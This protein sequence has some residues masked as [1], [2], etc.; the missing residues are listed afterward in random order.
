MGKFVTKEII[1]FDNINKYRQLSLDNNGNLQVSSLN[2]PT[3]NYQVLTKQ[4]SIY[5]GTTLVPLSRS[6][7]TLSLNG[8]GSLFTNTSYTFNSGYWANIYTNYLWLGT[9]SS[10]TTG[11]GAIYLHNLSKSYTW[12]TLQSSTST[13]NRVLTLPA[14]SNTLVAAGT[15]GAVNYI[16]VANSTTA[17]DAKWVQPNISFFTND[18]KYITASDAKFNDYVTLA[19]EQTISGKKNF[20]GGATIKGT[21]NAVI[22]FNGASA[23][24]DYAHI[25]V[26]GSS[27]NSRPLVLQNGYGNVAI[28]NIIAPTNKLEVE[29]N[30]KA[31]KFIGD[32]EASILSA[33]STTIGNL[34]VQGSSSLGTINSGTWNASKIDKSYLTLNSIT[35]GTA[36]TSSATSGSSIS[37]PY[38]SVDAQGLVTGYGTHTHTIPSSLPANGGYADYPTGFNSRSSSIGWGTLTTGN[39]YTYLTDWHTNAGS[40]IAFA[41]KS[42]A[43]SVQ[44]DGYF[45]QREGAARVLDT[46]DITSTNISNWNSTYNA[47]LATSGDVQGTIDRWDEV[48]SFLSTVSEGQ[49]L[50]SILQGYVT[51]NTAQTISGAKTFQSAINGNILGNATT[52]DRWS[53]THNFTIKDSDNTNSGTA[54]AVDGSTDYILHLP[55]TIKANITG[56]V[57]G[58][59]GS[60]AWTGITGKPDS[61][62]P[63]SHNHTV[64]KY[65]DSRDTQESPTTAGTYDGLRIDFKNKNTS[66]IPSNGTWTTVITMDGYSDATGGYPSQ[67][68]FSMSD[69]NATRRL[70]FRSP[71]NST[72]WGN[73]NTLAFTSDL[74]DYV[75]LDTEQTITGKKVLTGYTKVTKDLGYNIADWTTAQHNGPLEVGRKSNTWTLTLGVT[76]DSIGFIQN[77]AL[78]ISSP[79]FLVLNPQG[80]ASKTI[81]G[82][83]YYGSVGI[84][85][86]REPHYSLEVN[87]TLGISNAATLSSSLAVGTSLSVGTT[88]SFSGRAVFS[89]GT[90]NGYSTG[91]IEIRGNGE[92]NTNPGLGFHQPGK[93]AGY[94]KLTDWGQF[95]LVDEGNGKSNLTAQTLTADIATGT[96]PLNITSITKV[97][98]LNSDLLDGYHENYF[99]SGFEHQPFN[100]SNYTDYD[101]ENTYHKAISIITKPV[102]YGGITIRGIVWYQSSNDRNV[103]VSKFPF[104]INISAC[105]KQDHDPLIWVPKVVIDKF[106]WIFRVVRTSDY[107]YEV[108]I[109]NGTSRWAELTMIYQVS[110]KGGQT[111]TNYTTSSNTL[112]TAIATFDIASKAQVLSEDYCNYA[113]S[114][115]SATS[116]T[117]TTYLGNS[118]NNLSYSSLSGVASRTISSSTVGYMS[119][120]SDTNTISGTELF[121]VDATNSKLT[122]GGQLVTKAGTNTGAGLNGIKLASNSVLTGLRDDVLLLKNNALRFSNVDTWDYDKWAGLKYDS[123]NKYIYLG[124]ADGTIFTANNVQSNGKLLL[125]GIAELRLGSSTSANLV[126]HSGNF[127]AGTNYVTPSGS[128]TGS[129]GSCTGNSATATYWKMQTLAASTDLNTM[130]TSGYYSNIS[131]SS[132]AS[133][134]NGPSG[135]T[136]GEMWMDVRQAGASSYGSQTYYARGGESFQIYTRTWSSSNFS[137]WVQILHTENINSYAL[138]LS[139]NQTI[140]GNKTFSGTTSLSIAEVDSLTAGNLVVQGTISGRLE[141]TATG[142]TG[143]TFK[144]MTSAGTSGWT[145]NA[146]DDKIIPTMSVLAYWNGAYSGNSSNITKLGTISNGTWQASTIGL[147]YGGTGATTAAGARTNLGLDSL[148]TWYTTELGDTDTKINKW[149]EV[150]YFLSTITDDKTLGDILLGYVTKD[151][152]QTIIGAKTFESPINGD[153]LGNATTADRLKNGLPKATN[154]EIGG[155][156][157][158]TTADSSA[159]T[160]GATSGYTDS[161]TNRN[162][163]V[164]M[165]SN[166]VAYVNIPWRNDTYSIPT[167]TNYYA[168]NIQ[169]TSSA[170][171]IKE[172]EFK[173]IKINGST[174]NA[175]ST[176]NCVMQY[177]TTNKCLK[178][179]FNG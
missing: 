18:N 30:V 111:Y 101:S 119:Y 33:E 130:K 168:G 20:T 46:T 106:N 29:G 36:G 147:A 40:D 125:P 39:G 141:G 37:I 22:N 154:S 118:T 170:N 82:K 80:D 110:Q 162:Y 116:S 9:G 149:K 93:Y 161:G 123:T 158:S 84:N 126:Y 164:K 73:W 21:G 32:L 167:V 131:T 100:I 11:T 72:T 58:S 151:S 17:G 27:S 138:T 70:Y 178:F 99:Y 85:L 165:D 124:L 7:G 152:A 94:I 157:L 143:Y 78:N 177:D 25:F 133:F 16:L 77:K 23:T 117:Y 61:F 88:S 65:V 53:N 14:V 109:K 51:T 128:I 42:G 163:P 104:V 172:P 107:N 146:T 52:S 90:G 59:A 38:V 113:V 140:A 102:N 159:A 31:T 95:V 34:V 174:T 139:D 69:L 132:C 28:G 67:L 155:I 171:Y 8:L 50:A 26:N 86:K 175:A 66:L 103:A 176:S 142:L 134:V 156:K 62:N 19:T 145:N 68:G 81:N 15:P 148:Y 92:A 112:G 5:I 79:G 97:S 115:G 136:N 4:D 173:S 47:L 3:T 13:L 41:E 89:G 169:L 45:Y 76:D 83:T 91:A 75:T 1:L 160:L 135:R 57:S 71:I 49:D 122:L 10:N 150:E 35:S 120:Y 24:V 48:V 64:V 43:V 44:V 105:N 96:A 137:N 144:T 108:Q 98:N 12:T 63:T 2:S 179:I 153:L 166:G 121:T 54:T 6:S 129:A 114:A 74:S 55:S 60:V 87:G 56:N 127:I